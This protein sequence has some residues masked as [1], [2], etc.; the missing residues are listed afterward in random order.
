MRASF[1][2]LVQLT[3]EIISLPL[4]IAVGIQNCSLVVAIHLLYILQSLQVQ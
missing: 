2:S 4:K 3:E 1:G